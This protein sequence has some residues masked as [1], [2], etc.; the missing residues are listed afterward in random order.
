MKI[1]RLLDVELEAKR[2]R[3]IYWQFIGI[4]ENFGEERREEV[5]RISEYGKVYEKLI[6]PKNQVL[7]INVLDADSGLIETEIYSVEP[8]GSFPIIIEMAG[9]NRRIVIGD[10]L[11]LLLKSIPSL[12][13][14]EDLANIALV[15]HV[16]DPI[17]RMRIRRN[18]IRRSK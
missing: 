8:L 7:R 15:A 3:R 4:L 2:I 18:S 12:P 11:K 16:S 6:R 14:A 1:E 9:I 5:V 10:G 17:T 13:V